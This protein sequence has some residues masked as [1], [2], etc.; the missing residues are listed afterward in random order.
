[1]D[2]H[3]VGLMDTP[4]EEQVR[5][6]V[7]KQEAIM[8]KMAEMYSTRLDDQ[9]GQLHNQFVGFISESQLPLPQVLLVLQMLVH[10]TVEQAARQYGVG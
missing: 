8:K 2:L 10:E 7:E 9:M 1:M 3:R 4:N 5:R 6:A